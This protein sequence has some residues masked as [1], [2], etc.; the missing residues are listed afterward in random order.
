MAEPFRFSPRPNRAAEIH[1]RHWTP[2]AFEEATKSER[3]LL[4]I[5]TTRWCRSCQELDETTLSDPGVIRLL[6]EEVVPVRVDADRN[7]HIQERYISGGWPTCAFLAPTG[8]VFW[9]GTY[10]S[11]QEMRR[12]ARGVLDGWRDRRAE[13]EQEIVRRRKAMEAARS[14]RPAIGIIRR[15]P[16]DDVL[17]GAEQQFDTRN[18][19][20]GDAPKF[21]HAEAVE[22]LFTQGERADNPD[23][24]L[25]AERTLD[26]MIAGEIEDRA[27]G[28]FFHYALE[29]DW[30]RPQTEKLLS[31]NARALG[32]FAFGAAARE[33][34]DWLAAAER[35][36]AWADQTLARDGLWVGSQAADPDYYA[37]PAEE[38]AALEPPPVD[39]TVYADS[40]AMWI[41]SLADAGRRLGR[42]DWTER[43][44][45]ALSAFFDQLGEEVPEGE[46]LRHYRVPGGDPPSGLLLDMLHGARACVA[47]A[48]AT[49]DPG[50]LARAE[51]IVARM[52]RTLWE[53]S[54][55]F[56]DHPRDIPALGALRFRDRPFEEN[57]VASRLL[58]DLYRRTGERSYRAMAER[59]LALLAPL[60]GRYSV[61]G[62]TFAMAVE[63]FF[64]ARP[65]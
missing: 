10:V 21:I 45:A 6:N 3:P 42:D 39:D 22:L 61:E 53:E 48:A 32:A 1:W 40:C 14:R 64:E 55:G 11:A 2:A 29:P 49:D 41:A 12:V 28:G 18:G 47:V 57:S 37:A 4:L 33:R 51:R 26:G 62:A 38:R 43:A 31:I 58:L 44:R 9:S 30:T 23:W 59:T 7:P 16:A 20:F 34:D 56:A 36:V 27:A 60:A 15:E 54:G 13:L 8:E 17:M 35:T 19:G 46:S 52:E 24:A 5:L 63:E 25:I 65:R 50:A